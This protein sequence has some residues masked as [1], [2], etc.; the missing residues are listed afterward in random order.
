MDPELWSTHP[1]GCTVESSRVVSR[2]CMAGVRTRKSHPC[3]APSGPPFR[4][5][6]WGWSFVIPGALMIFLGLLIFA[7]LVVH[8]QDVGM[9]NPPE[10]CAPSE[11]YELQPL[12]DK[13]DRDKE[14]AG[15]AS[16]VLRCPASCCVA[17]RCVALRCVA[18]HCVVSCIAVLLLCCVLLCFAALCWTT[19]SYA[20]MLVLGHTLHAYARSCGPTCRRVV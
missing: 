13:I 3:A 1:L 4:P 8:P 18:L 16:G 5:Q 9:V 19:L 17:L 15:E 20:Q 7:F 12:K 6:G 14:K 10:N 2:S 11:E